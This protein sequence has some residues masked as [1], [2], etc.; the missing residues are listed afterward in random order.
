MDT[1]KYLQ[2][3]SLKLS[4]LENKYDYI[5]N[6]HNIKEIGHSIDRACLKDTLKIASLRNKNGLSSIKFSEKKLFE[7]RQFAIL[8]NKCPDEF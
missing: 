2:L 4:E 1:K 5:A 3:S 7:K 6:E 8:G